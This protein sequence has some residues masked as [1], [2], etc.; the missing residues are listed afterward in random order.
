M[1]IETIFA[2]GF[3]VL[4]SGSMMLL[5]N[6]E[7]VTTAL[8][9]AFS[10]KKR[11]E[12]QARKK[13]D[14]L[15]NLPFS[16]TNYDQALIVYI[17]RLERARLNGDAQD[18]LRN[19]YECALCHYELKQFDVSERYVLEALN[20]ARSA[21]L[22][23]LPVAAQLYNLLGCLEQHRQEFDAAIKCYDA[24]SSVMSKWTFRAP[25]QTFVDLHRLFQTNSANCRDWRGY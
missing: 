20:N 25:S 14:E 4:L 23:D 3:I 16:S 22:M 24:A 2:I 10:L 19:A 8:R 17:S 11:R 12:R 1:K 6:W 18:E 5:N 7:R 21:S 15:C 9:T 13:L